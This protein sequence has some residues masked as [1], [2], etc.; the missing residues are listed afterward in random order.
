M[1]GISSSFL[2]RFS[3]M[4]AI[5]VKAK[6][7]NWYTNNPFIYQMIHCRTPFFKKSYISLST[8]YTY[9]LVNDR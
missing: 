9:K 1:N 8:D 7:H 5:V 2:G 3:I 6:V 4:Y